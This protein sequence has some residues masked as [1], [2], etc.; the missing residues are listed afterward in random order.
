MSFFDKFNSEFIS[1]KRDNKK[2][3][4]GDSSPKILDKFLKSK[5]PELRKELERAV[6]ADEKINYSL[7]PPQAK[8]ELGG[9]DAPGKIRRE[10]FAKNGKILSL[11][12][13]NYIF[14]DGNIIDDPRGVIAKLMAGKG[15]KDKIIIGENIFKGGNRD[16]E[17][18]DFFIN[19]SGYK[20]S[21][22][23]DI[24]RR[25][26]K[27]SKANGGL[28]PVWELYGLFNKKNEY[29]LII[30]VVGYADSP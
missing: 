23:D 1:F 11:S 15:Y 9:A 6:L 20:V 19:G 8:S 4:K 28:Y 27:L 17:G 12:N 29:I 10:D 2:A 22:R 5:A 18:R 7:L 3:L 30:N 16:Q 24:K 26:N 14:N 21:T 25:F 13:Q